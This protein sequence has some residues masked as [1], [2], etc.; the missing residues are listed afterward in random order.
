MKDE[1]SVGVESEGVSQ[2]A[3]LG[4]RRKELEPGDGNVDADDAGQRLVVGVT[5]R[6]EHR[7]RYCR[8]K[9]KSLHSEVKYQSFF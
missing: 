7:K 8:H 9:T 4:A 5:R 6:V 3:Q 2:R 1:E